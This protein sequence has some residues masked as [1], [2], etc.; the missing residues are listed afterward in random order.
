VLLTEEQAK[1]VETEW[2]SFSH[3]Q[4]RPNLN[5]EEMEKIRPKLAQRFGRAP[6]DGDVAWA[7][8]NKMAGDAAKKRQWGLYRNTRLSM[9]AALEQEGKLSRSFCFYLEA[10]YLD[11]NGP[12]NVGEIVSF[13]KHSF[14]PNEPNFKASA[15][16]LSPSVI[17]KLLEI[18]NR[19]RLGEDQVRLEFMKTAERD[20]QNLKLPVSPDKAWETLSASLYV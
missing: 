12:Q 11:L 10:C 15:V 20:Y 1:L 17:D 14:F 8:L 6:S 3:P 2:S 4:I 16:V 5:V 13:G 7:Y 9:G 18:I 19:L